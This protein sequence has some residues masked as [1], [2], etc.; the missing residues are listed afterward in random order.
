[1]LLV[2]CA[3]GVEHEADCAIAEARFTMC[4]GT[5]DGD[6]FLRGSDT[7][8]WII[9]RRDYGFLLFVI[10]CTIRIFISICDGF[11][12]R[13]LRKSRKALYRGFLI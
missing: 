7:L 6:N 1:M 3:L 11:F 2:S 10:Y 13:R 12:R 4:R 5:V 8:D 9:A